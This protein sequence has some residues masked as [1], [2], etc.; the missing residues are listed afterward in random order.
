[1]SSTG[2][3][4]AAINPQSKQKVTDALKNLGLTASWLGE[5]TKI[6]DRTLIKGKTASAFPSRPND[7]YS[8]ILAKTTS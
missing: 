8:L 1:M 6:K 7:P 4:L 3:I 5:F 2:T